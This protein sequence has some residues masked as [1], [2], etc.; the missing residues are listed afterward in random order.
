VRKPKLMDVK[1][2][3]KVEE[4]DRQTFPHMGRTCNFV[5]PVGT[6]MRTGDGWNDEESYSTKHCGVHGAELLKT[7]A[8]AQYL[9]EAGVDDLAWTACT[10]TQLKRCIRLHRDRK[11]SSQGNRMMDE[12]GVVLSISEGVPQGS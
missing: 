10:Q 3:S 11:N 7:N 1:L 6:V 12:V 5:I 9:G 4:C 8:S 2:S